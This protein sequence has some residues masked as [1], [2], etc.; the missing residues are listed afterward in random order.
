MKNTQKIVAEISELTKTIE[1]NYPEIYKFLDENPMTIPSENHPN[2][3]E[4][5]L[6]EYL[7]SLKQFL[8]HHID[9]HI[10]T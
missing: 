8:K 5:V 7:E 3:D 4:N 6:Q 2:I 9:T 1:T 10:K